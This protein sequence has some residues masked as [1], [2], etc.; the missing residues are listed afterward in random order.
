[1]MARGGVEQE[2][3][4]SDLMMMTRMR[5]RGGEER[6]SDAGSGGGKV[7]PRR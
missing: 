7:V 6:V 3:E 4:R 5:K 1:M 2:R